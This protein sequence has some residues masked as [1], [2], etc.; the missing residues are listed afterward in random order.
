VVVVKSLW[1][2]RELYSEVLTK[3]VSVTVCRL[4]YEK[5]KGTY[6][7]GFKYWNPGGI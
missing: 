1:I 6:A 4:I 3:I 2:E 7:Q 5:L